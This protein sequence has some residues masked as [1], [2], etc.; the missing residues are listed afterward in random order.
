[1]LNAVE[2]GKK[3]N[4]GVEWT[5]DLGKVPQKGWEFEG[6]PG[7]WSM[8]AGRREDRIKLGFIKKVT[9]NF[10]GCNFLICPW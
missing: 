7:K 10:K 6:K 2:I 5:S 3:E 9:V 8:G 1:M 4:R